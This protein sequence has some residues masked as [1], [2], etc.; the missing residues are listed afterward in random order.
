MEFEFFLYLK[1]ETGEWSEEGERGEKMIK[2]NRH[3]PIYS[4]PQDT[5]VAGRYLIQDFLEEREN[6]LIYLAYDLAGEK[7][8]RLTECYPKQLVE[9]DG[10]NGEENLRIHPG[11]ETEMKS[12]LGRFGKEYKQTIPDHNTLYAVSQIQKKK[13]MGTVALCTAVIVLG[14]GM[15]FYTLRPS[16]QK[17]QA[18]EPSKVSEGK[19][20][21][22][23]NGDYIF[24]AGT[25]AIEVDTDS[26]TMYFDR[27]L[28]VY[29]DSELSDSQIENLLS[30]VDGTLV[31]KIAGR[32]NILQV[33]IPESGFAVLEEKSQKLME[34]EN[35]LFAGYD[36]PIQ[37]EN[38]EVGKDTNPWDSEK[39]EGGSEYD[40]GVPNGNNWWAEAIGAYTAWNNLPELSDE[41]L[42]IVD[43][44]FDTGH[45]DLK[46]KIT[47]T[48]DTKN[49]KES[50]GTHVAGIAGAINNDIG[51]RGIADSAQILGVSY[52]DYFDT[53]EFTYAVPLQLLEANRILIEQGAKVVNNSWGFTLMSEDAYKETWSVDA[54]GLLYQE[55]TEEQNMEMDY[56]GYVH[57]YADVLA[58]RTAQDAERMMEQL[59][60]SATTEEEKEFMIVQSAGN[61]FDNMM[62]KGYD[63]S[64]QGF[65]CGITADTHVSETYSY[66]EMKNHIMV[67]SAVQNKRE[68]GRYQIVEGVNQGDTVDLWAP[69]WDVYSCVSTE[70]S[71]MYQSANGTSMAAPMAA[72]S[73]LLIW[74]IDPSLSA[75]EVK[76]TLL[77]HASEAYLPSD[78]SKVYPMLNI[79]R[80]VLALQGREDGFTGYLK[81]TLIPKYGIM[82]TDSWKLDNSLPTWSKGDTSP[83][84]GILSAY[85]A[86]FDGDEMNE[87]LVVRFVQEENKKIHLEMYEDYKGSIDLATGIMFDIDWLCTTCQNNRLSVMADKKNG[88]YQIYLYAFQR[89]NGGGAETIVKLN[90]EE[91]PNK[92]MSVLEP[93]NYWSFIMGSDQTA[94]VQSGTMKLKEVNPLAELWDYKRGEGS[95][96]VEYENTAKAPYESA[97][98]AEDF[99]NMLNT[100]YGSLQEATGLKH[101]IKLAQSWSNAPIETYVSADDENSQE[102]QY[103]AKTLFEEDDQLQWLASLDNHMYH[104][105]DTNTIQNTIIPEDAT[106][107]VRK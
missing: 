93:E 62:E 24:D 25:E 19:T 98:Y 9:R 80:T 5:I 101:N 96:Q 99:A 100:F 95:A 53:D 103:T 73:A 84:N 27:T 104:N 18:K 87:M 43:S 51:I 76:Q 55:Q 17:E 69:G 64:W 13:P 3:R 71:E 74:E 6:R 31:G 11:K 90:Y 32:M 49:R 41:I 46:G 36:Y 65:F 10:E 59:L 26:G 42:G 102:M 105:R 66:E 4:L 30:V 56:E 37:I 63:A 79:G 1:Q 29:L 72:S 67:V 61:G 2:D 50:H 83:A 16:G 22:Y 92:G 89:G 34:Q 44:G 86:D 39:K 33:Q 57:Y 81:E 14:V 12:L 20:Q 7:Q 52:A 91:R 40:E 47:I 54:V 97:S 82:S 45:P 48:G 75:G 77:D 68:K 70:G 107:I 106:E 58:K 78:E 23:E 94:S 85:I 8:I 88:Y 21:T 35:V 60:N 28:Q 15:L 38:M